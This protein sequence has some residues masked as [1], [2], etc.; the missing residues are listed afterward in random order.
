MSEY[1]QIQADNALSQIW[2]KP[3]RTLAFLLANHPDKYVLPLLV[4]GGITRAID[5]A[6]MKDMGD[7]MS[8]ATILLTAVLGG[9]LFGW[10]SYYLY[11]WLLSTTGRW[12][13]GTA[14]SHKFRTVIAWALVPS[15][16]SLALVLPEVVVFGEDLFKSEPENTSH[17]N[18][19]MWGVVSLLQATLGIWTIVILVK[20]TA[21]VQNFTTGKAI[22]NLILP[23][24]V[25]FAP[26]ML[27]LL[28]IEAFR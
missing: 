27:L 9:G 26:F 3:K 13:Q 8:T 18:N 17:F 21:L 20:G 15:V 28:L 23:G 14:S 5:R 24:L 11:A 19:I 12:L 10:L 7:K 6:S 16:V 22:L 1:P 4:L 25:V 2:F